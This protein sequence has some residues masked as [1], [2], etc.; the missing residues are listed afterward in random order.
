MVITSEAA[1]GRLNDPRNLVVKLRMFNGGS[2]KLGK[3][4]ISKDTK[5]LI[6]TLARLKVMPRKDLMELTGVGNDEITLCRNGE[7]SQGVRDPEI[8]GKVRG[9]TEEVKETVKET[10]VDNLL[11]AL[12]VVKAK[13]NGAKLLEAS[14]VAKDSAIIFEKMNGGGGTGV[15]ATKVV[16][17][18]PGSKS[19]DQYMSVEV[20]AGAK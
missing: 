13:I 14:T 17:H 12:G 15:L 4:N 7:S 5:A 19:E 18:D 6:G 1:E 9:T 11:I 20:I 8:F 16:I 10:A 2:G 3:E